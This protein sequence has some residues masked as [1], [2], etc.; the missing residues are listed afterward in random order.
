MVK[1]K[2]YYKEKMETE[3][4]IINGDCVEGAYV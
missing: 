4:K 1:T 2:I 3:H